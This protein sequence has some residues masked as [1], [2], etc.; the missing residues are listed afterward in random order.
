MTVATLRRLAGA[1]EVS[2]G[3]LVGGA[4]PKNRSHL[5]LSRKSLDRVARYLIKG[6]G[7]LSAEEKG[8]AELIGSLAARKLK[9]RA[10]Y[11]RALPRTARKE[12][13][14]WEQAGSELGPLQIQNL[15][16]RIDKLSKTL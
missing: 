3:V 12:R 16:N 14:S 1:L 11:G 5:K 7:F 6:K 15:L 10:R 2:P 13:H 9:R 4:L 8:V